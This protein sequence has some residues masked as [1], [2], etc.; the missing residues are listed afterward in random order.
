[1]RHRCRL[2]RSRGVQRLP[3]IDEAGAIR[4]GVRVDEQA[5]HVDADRAARAAADLG[6]GPSACGVRLTKNPDFGRART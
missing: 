4:S 5:A 2:P 6:A 1:M 3:E